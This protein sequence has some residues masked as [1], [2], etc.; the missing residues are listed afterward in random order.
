M[1]SKLIRPPTDLPTGRSL[2]RLLEALR[3]PTGDGQGVRVR[4]QNLKGS[5]RGYLLARVA[6]SLEVPLVCVTQDEDEA[7]K[8]A[9]D[10]GF[11][12]GGEGDLLHPNVVHM[13]GDEVLPYD[14]LSPDPTL[15]SGR[16]GAL[17][18]LN[19]ATRFPALVLSIRALMKRVL[20]QSLMSGL[21][22]HVRVEQDYERDALARKL[23]EMGYA[24]VPL[25]EDAGTFSIRGDI[26][27]VF[28]PLYPRPVR[29][30]FFGDIIE[31]MRAFDPETQRTVD[32]LK[33][34]VLPPTRELLFNSHTR[35]NAE[36]A[37]RAAAE[38]TNI[39]TS[40]VRERLDAIREG[41]HSVGM[42]AM[43]PGFFAGGLSTV[44]DYLGKWSTRQ[45]L[46]YLD[47]PMGIDRAVAH[48]E[49]ELE[50]EYANVVNLGELAEP[51]ALHYLGAGELT[52]RLRTLRVLEGGGL[53]LD[54]GM[55]DADGKSE[56]VAFGFATTKDLRDAILSHHGEEGALTPLLDRL[57]RWRDQSIATV[58]ACGSL[59]QA[60]RLKRLLLERNVAVKV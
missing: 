28:S 26:I 35:P 41:M 6:R 25:V 48:L 22:E 13:P 15:V 43:L 16:L 50:R 36:A 23:V 4:T 24:S 38:R 53:S 7:E 14:E 51:P 34:L 10:L 17:F 30:E 59:G 3:A 60:D 19:Q 32:S 31:S 44:F 55:G 37:I 58:V 29:L 21:S 46:F 45:P 56:S 11:F 18:H 40:R 52:G 33:E 42:E 57:N 54:L 47:D 20:P 49:A 1:E 5:A 27:D 39:P 12:L 8:L 2:E 9:H